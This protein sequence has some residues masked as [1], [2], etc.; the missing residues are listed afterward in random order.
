MFVGRKL[1]EI[2]QCLEA[3]SKSIKDKQIT[4]LNVNDNAIGLSV[5][6][7][8]DFILSGIPTLEVLKINNCGL[9][10][11]VGEIIAAAFKEN[12]DLKLKQFTAGR[13]RLENRGITALASVFKEM[14][15]LEVIEV[16]QNGIKKE[17]MLALLE[18]LKENA[19]TLREIKIEDNWIKGQAVDKLAE[20]ILKAKKLE[21]LNIS[22]SNMGSEGALLVV[23]AIQDSEIKNTLKEFYC[24]YNEVEDK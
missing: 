11:D 24:N 7:S 18:A 6:K 14:K 16:P 22:D 12:K 2:P 1:D 15:S 9:G 8:L 17:G 19:E 5:I 21:K 10:P 4:E 23:R 13:D 20:L 3:L